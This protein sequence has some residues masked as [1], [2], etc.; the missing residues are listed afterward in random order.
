MKKL[1][2]LAILGGLFL[3]TFLSIDRVEYLD[4]PYDVRIGSVN[5][6]EAAEVLKQFK[7][8][9][10]KN[11]KDLEIDIVINS[12]GGSVHI[13][14]EFIE[15]MK[16]LKEKGYHLNCYARNAYSMGFIILQYCDT[17]IGSSNSTYMHHLT[18]IG[19]GRPKRNEHNKQLFK[20]LDF[21]D[22]L[23]LNEIAKKMKVDPDKFF[24]KIKEDKWWNAKDALKDG[25]LDKIENFS[26]VV[27]K[28]K[29]KFV[30][31]WRKY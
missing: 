24:E 3:A 29:Y 2:T 1:L 26:L 18:Q 11:K 7:N 9:E 20:A 10:I 16:V 15:E 4:S 21:F 22:K 31:F 28:V 30:P 14:L 25:I 23:V 12:G 13:G 17:R 5:N 6:F 8:A 19:W 27:K